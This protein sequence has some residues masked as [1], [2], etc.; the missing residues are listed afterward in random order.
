MK[1]IEAEQ[2]TERVRRFKSKQSK[3]SAGI[4]RGTLFKGV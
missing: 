3:T 2:V 4:L 1:V